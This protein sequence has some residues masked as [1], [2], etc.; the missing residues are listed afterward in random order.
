MTSLP[1]LLAGKYNQVVAAR[2]QHQ[3]VG[4]LD[5]HL[6]RLVAGGHEAQ[7]GAAGVL[8]QVGAHAA[9][10]AG[11]L[12]RPRYPQLAEWRRGPGRSNRRPRCAEPPPP[13]KVL[14]TA[15]GS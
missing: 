10:G 8:D 7:P 1:G 3:G 5:A 6:E 14:V 12:V 13:Q 11:D 15:A 9:V 2:V 4:V